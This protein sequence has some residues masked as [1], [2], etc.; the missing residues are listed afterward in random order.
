MLIYINNVNLGTK[1]QTLPPEI[2]K[3]FFLNHNKTSLQ[4]HATPIVKAGT[5][6]VCKRTIQNNSIVGNF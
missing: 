4:K 3:S 1:I 6:N 5:S 2:V